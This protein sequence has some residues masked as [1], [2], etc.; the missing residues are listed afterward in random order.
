M[1]NHTRFGSPARF[2]FG[3]PGRVS[4]RRPAQK[5]RS[6]VCRWERAADGC[7]EMTWRQVEIGEQAPG[8]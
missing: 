7:L 2:K 3:P 6:L 8:R 1:V 4:V 5:R